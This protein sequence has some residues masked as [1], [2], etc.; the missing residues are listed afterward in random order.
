MSVFRRARPSTDSDTST[1]T[2]V[3]DIPDNRA[4]PH[5]QLAWRRDLYEMRCLTEELLQ[6]T[7]TDCLEAYEALCQAQRDNVPGRIAVAYM[8]FETATRLAQASTDDRDRIDALIS[9]DFGGGAAVPRA[10][11][12]PARLRRFIAALWKRR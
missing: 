10:A 11:T 7:V 6:A 9:A 3:D 1:S 12:G 5:I 4:E 2:P 8:R